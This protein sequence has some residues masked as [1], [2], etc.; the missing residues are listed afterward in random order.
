MLSNNRDVAVFMLR[1]PIFFNS[2]IYMGGTQREDNATW[3]YS[4][5]TQLQLL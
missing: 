3:T 5:N 4:G 1:W 2:T